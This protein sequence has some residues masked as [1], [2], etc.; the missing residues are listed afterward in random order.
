MVTPFHDPF[1]FVGVG[2]LRQLL[3]ALIS[4]FVVFERRGANKR[5]NKVL[6]KAG[7]S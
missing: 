5:E 3:E 6:Q 2:M 7:G 4:S 1:A